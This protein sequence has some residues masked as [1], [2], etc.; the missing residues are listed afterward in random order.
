[1]KLKPIGSTTLKVKGKNEL[2]VNDVAIGEVWLCS[3]QS[4][5]ELMVQMSTDQPADVMQGHA[6]IRL[7]QI[8]QLAYPQAQT[9]FEKPTQWQVATADSIKR[10]A[11]S[12]F[13]AMRLRDSLRSVA[14]S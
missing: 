10:F 1:M 12:G 2:T 11:M 6:A 9:T 14:R 5:M 7:L 4:N 3:G 8:A 13:S